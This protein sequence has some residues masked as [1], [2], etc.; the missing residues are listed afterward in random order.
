MIAAAVAAGTTATFGAPLGGVL[1]SI[2][3]ASTYYM[4]SNLWKAFFCA[5]S[6]IL[7]FRYL[8]VYQTI[9]LFDYTK[10]DA[11]DMDLEIFLYALL[12]I[13]CGII[14]ALFVHVLTKIIFLRDRLKLPFI[15]N[16]F[17]WSIFVGLVTGLISFPVEFMMITDKTVINSM[18]SVESITT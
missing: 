15:T 7:M 16:S 11:I 14:G 9:E 10:F 4:V 18:F 8:E 1:F 12:G 17:Y 6:S 2:E 13:L 3:V 5:T